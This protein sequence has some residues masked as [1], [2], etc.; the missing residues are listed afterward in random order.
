MLSVNKYTKKYIKECKNKIALQLSAYEKLITAV[1]KKGNTKNP[2]L[3]AVIT[4]FESNFFNNMVVVLDA[5]FIHRS[6]TL[7]LKDGNPCNE[8]RM[9]SNSIM[10]NNSIFI[11]D[12]TI[13][14]HPEKSVLQYKNGK[15]IKLNHAYFTVLS[16]AFFA[17]I[18]SKFV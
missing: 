16:K 6:R 9:L 10:T 8:V 14:Y 18:E 13:K 12:K 15:P 7:E 4:S 1:E 17:D 11:A 5:L 2:G 3:E